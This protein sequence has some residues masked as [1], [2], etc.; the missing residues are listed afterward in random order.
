MARLSR[1]RRLG[2]M[3][4]SGLPSRARDRIALNL[5]VRSLRRCRERAE[6][7]REVCE[8]THAW[9]GY[10]PYSNIRSLQHLE[11]QVPF[12]EFVRRR[13]IQSAL[14]IGTC[15]GGTLLPLLAVADP[16]ARVISIDLPGGI[17]GG[18]Y[19]PCWVEFFQRG[20]RFQRQRLDMVR[21]NSQLP[22]TLDHVRRL[23]GDSQ[24]DYLFIDGDHRYAG[25]RQDL[26]L[27]APLV[28]RGGI[29]AFHDIAEGEPVPTVD[30]PRLWR[31]IRDLAPSVEFIRAEP[32]PPF[33]GIG[34]FIDWDTTVL[35][36]IREQT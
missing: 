12:F 34:A 15:R 3:L 24:L 9:T 22:E 23:L 28:R 1:T 33:Y 30:V 19:D 26:R 18:G 11:E 2:S 32:V 4:A 5:S 27:Y 17:H 10:G 20:F 25:V 36:R 8:L 7:V 31:E 13:K 21:A 16:G 14:E 35:D 6:G 29:V